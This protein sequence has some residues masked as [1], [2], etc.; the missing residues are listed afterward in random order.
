VK[1]FHCMVFSSLEV[2]PSQQNGSFDK[3]FPHSPIR[4]FHTSPLRRLS[5]LTIIAILTLSCL[6]GPCFVLE[7]GD[8]PWN[9]QALSNPPKMFEVNDHTS[10]EVKTIFYEGLP[11]KGKRTRVFAYYG[12]PKTRGKSKVP[13]MVL[14]HGGGGSAYIPWVQLWVNRGYAAIAMD[15]CGAMSGGGHN[16]HLRHEH[17]GPSGWGGFEQIDDPIEDQWTYHAVA[18]VILAHSLIRSFPEVDPNKIGLS[19]ISWGGFLSC[20]VGG[21]DSRFRFVAPVYGCGFLGENSVWLPDF[22]KMGHDKAQ[23]WL[24]LWDPSRYLHSAQV[25]YLWVTG[26]TDFAFPMDSLQKSYRLTKGTR[27]LCIRVGMA[28]GHGGPGENPGEIHAMADAVLKN[29][30]P[31][32]RIVGSHRDGTKASVNF[33]SESPIRKAELNYTT[34][35]GPWQNRHWIT[36]PASLN[37]GNKQ[38]TAQIPANAKIYFFNIVDE[39]NLVVS[40][41]HERVSGN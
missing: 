41:E 15:T 9:M 26:T 6:T 7:A 40:S 16:N 29:G 10:G 25:P 19:G 13:A 18:D 28:H 38:A 22:E 35:A 11:W 2:S 20:I 1:F 8:L 4:G 30:L 5:W 33:E 17:S 23:R 32:P 27:V 39:R 14:V 21:V 24:K 12:I 3:P 36:I 34:D 37:A 31:L